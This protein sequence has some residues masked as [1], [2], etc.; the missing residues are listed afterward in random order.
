MA[1]GSAHSKPR[2]VGIRGAH[3]DTFAMLSASFAPMPREENYLA[4]AFQ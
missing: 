4:F 2:E 3:S 1:P